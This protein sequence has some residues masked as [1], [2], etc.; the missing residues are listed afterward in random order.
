MKYFYTDQFG[1]ICSCTETGASEQIP[2]SAI[3]WPD[4]MEFS[5]A[6][7]FHFNSET[8]QFIKVNLDLKPSI[9]HRFNCKTMQWEYQQ[10]I[11]ELCIRS[12]RNSKL[13]EVDLIVTNPLRW[14]SFSEATKDAYANYRKCLL[15]VPQQ[16][17][18]PSNVVWPTPLQG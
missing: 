9:F 15:D 3:K 13:L 1:K 12:E 11:A 8:N 2:E 18:F 5:L 4:N 6:L 17:G 14:S 16:A 7:D 10:E